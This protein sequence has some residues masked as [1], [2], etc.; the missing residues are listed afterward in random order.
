[1]PKM[2]VIHPKS[3]FC[4]VFV[5]GDTGGAVAPLLAVAEQVKHLQPGA[6]LVF[7]G[8]C[9]GPEKRMAEK[10]GL[11]F[12]G[13]SAGKLR[14]YFSLKNFLS[15][16][17]TIKG[18]VQALK[19]LKAVRPQVIMGA[20]GYVQVPVIWA[21]K[22]LGIP[23]LIHQQDVRPGL[24]NKLCELAANRI[25]VTFESSEKQFLH[26]LGL[27]FAK[28]KPDKVFWTG[29]PVRASLKSVQQEEAVKF[30]GLKPDFPTVLVMGGGTG[31]IFINRLLSLS[32]E[33]LVKFCQILHL[34]G[35]REREEKLGPGLES[36]NY[37]VLE[38]TDRMDL[39]YAAADIVVCRAGLSTISELSFLK[40]TAIVIPMPDS[41]QEENANLLDLTN[42]AIVVT[43]NELDPKKF[44]HGLRKL[45]FEHKLQQSL[46]SNMSKLMPH[47]ASEKIAK[48]LLD[49]GSR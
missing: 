45:L 32:L 37:H 17:V 36:Q 12:F 34:T 44:G 43:Q 21:G 49:L 16:L 25:T 20:G 26:G 7:F 11:D 23:S 14:R 29:N 38:F 13:L 42:S 48:M 46:K 27:S 47:N 2:S 8:T 19:L 22:V 28:K 15:P 4:A 3:K 30:F 33:D 35:N 5:G 31:S 39:A 24:A 6:R 40:K 41:H 9:H 1:M 10:A 18:F